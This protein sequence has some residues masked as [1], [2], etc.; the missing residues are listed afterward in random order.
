M[1]RRKTLLNA[2]R[3]FR[4]SRWARDASTLLAAAGID[5][6]RRPERPSTQAATSSASPSVLRA[7][8]SLKPNN[9]KPFYVRPVL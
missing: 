1:Q 2:L 7:Y 3:P 6:V 5:P 9:L 8:Q 4:A